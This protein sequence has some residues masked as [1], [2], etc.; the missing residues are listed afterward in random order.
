M[1]RHWG[2]RF[3]APSNFPLYTKTNY[4]LPSTAR[5]TTTKIGYRIKLG[6]AQ[7][8]CTGIGYGVC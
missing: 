8:Q 5:G 6:H 7:W 1:W 4:L 3:T 2:W